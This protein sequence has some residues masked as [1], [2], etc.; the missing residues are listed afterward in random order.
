MSRK[1][2]EDLQKAIDS[3][4][5]IFRILIDSNSA[6]MQRE[7]HTRDV[8]QL[9]ESSIRTST[10][11]IRDIYE[12]LQ[13]NHTLLINIMDEEKTLL[14][15]AIENSMTEIQSE[16][17]NLNQRLG[18]KQDATMLAVKNLDSVVINLLEQIRNK[19]NQSDTA[20]SAMKE[21]LNNQFSGVET[22]I[23]AVL[24]ELDDVRNTLSQN[25]DRISAA[26]SNLA[27]SSESMKN[28]ILNNIAKI[29]DD[30]SLKLDSH[31]NYVLDRIES[32][33]VEMLGKI[34]GISEVV[35]LKLNELTTGINQ[36]IDSK[37]QDFQNTLAENRRL[38]SGAIE[39]SKGEILESQNTCLVKVTTQSDQLQSINSKIGSIE[40]SSKQQVNLLTNL[41]EKIESQKL[42][43]EKIEE[44]TSKM[45]L[46]ISE[47]EEQKS[48]TDQLDQR[49][50]DVESKIEQI[51]KPEPEP[52]E[53][54][55]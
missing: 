7:D 24:S 15:N 22:Q 47:V 53:E 14:K 12:D 43:I 10:K 11:E 25:Q 8:I 5:T 38:I 36:L 45:E 32:S 34:D 2:E 48:R 39:S 18:E 21:S 28:E 31:S 54:G 27:T 51:S 23:N 44:Q 6:I 42:S 9:L 50:S 3:I 55:E 46:S 40:D 4:G 29:N 17:A 49:T 20:L 13:K 16:Y 52:P 19:L 37:F 35:T 1:Y 26:I 41:I 30:F 33:K